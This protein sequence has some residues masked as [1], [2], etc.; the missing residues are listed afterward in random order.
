LI[1]ITRQHAMHAECYIVL[2]NSSVS[3]SHSGLYQNECT[4]CQTFSTIC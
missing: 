4:Y 2:A 1:F 3:P